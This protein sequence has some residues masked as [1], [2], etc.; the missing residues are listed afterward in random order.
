MQYLTLKD[1]KDLRQE[2]IVQIM[3][4]GRIPIL[5]V[6]GPIVRPQLL[7][8]TT[9][10]SLIISGIKVALYQ[11]VTTTEVKVKTPPTEKALEKLAKDM[12]PKTVQPE[13]KVEKTVVEEKAKVEAKEG[14]KVEEPTSV[15]KQPVEAKV[16]TY[17][18]DELKNK[19]N[20][21]L[22][23]ILKQRKVQFDTKD[24]NELI[25]LVITSNPEK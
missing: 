15:E 17:T 1:V 2:E 6:H 14:V 18:Y 22:K 5:N 16:V 11:S 13:Q 23:E 9:I 25:N 8:K 24:R 19:G 3:S 21:D 10:K 4:T 20:N 7:S 12:E